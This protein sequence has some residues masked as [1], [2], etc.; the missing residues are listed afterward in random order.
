MFYGNDPFKRHLTCSSSVNDAARALDLARWSMTSS[1]TATLLDG[2]AGG[3]TS[4][5]GVITASSTI[6]PPEQSPRLSK[7]GSVSWVSGDSD[8]FAKK[9]IMLS[10]YLRGLAETIM[11]TSIKDI[12][13]LR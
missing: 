13:I 6:G 4:V 11:R 1:K 7:I 12:G 3:D 9:E 10:F 8:I 5:F 2:L